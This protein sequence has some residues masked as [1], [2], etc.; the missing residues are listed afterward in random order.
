MAQRK[1]AQ[2]KKRSKWLWFG[3]PF[4]MILL[5]SGIFVYWQTRLLTAAT[6]ERD[7]RSGDL[8]ETVEAGKLPSFA[9]AEGPKVQE[10]Y[11]YASENPETL[12]Y[13]PCY[14]GCGGIGHTS[15]LSCYV[16]RINDNGTVT[17]NNHGAA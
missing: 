4:G 2:W 6:I 14:C 12:K 9:L 17:F 3:L 1:K 13:I 8:W 11:R 5:I 15:N 7:P 10:V 16:R